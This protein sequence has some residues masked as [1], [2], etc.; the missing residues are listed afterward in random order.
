MTWA[1]TGGSDNLIGGGASGDGNLVSGN[2][3][4]GVDLVEGHNGALSMNWIEF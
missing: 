4:D 2:A 3:G 1:R